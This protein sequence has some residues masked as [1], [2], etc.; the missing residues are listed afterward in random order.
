LVWETHSWTCPCT[1][2]SPCTFHSCSKE[3]ILP[4]QCSNQQITTQ[5]F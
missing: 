4:S 2:S 5:F 1:W 3:I